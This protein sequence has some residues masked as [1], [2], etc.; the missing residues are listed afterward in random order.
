MKQQH[1]L[2][3]LNLQPF[4]I[5]ERRDR[6]IGEKDRNEGRKGNES[7][8]PQ[9]FCPAGRPA[10]MAVGKRDCQIDRDIKP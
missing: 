5:S 10:E 1:G 2:S 4:I 9:L 3:S 6:D 7:A 8:E